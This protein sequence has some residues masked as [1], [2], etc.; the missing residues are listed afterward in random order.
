MVLR[1]RL[2]ST[3][4]A[5]VGGI[6]VFFHRLPANAEEDTILNICAQ[7]AIKVC[8]ITLVDPPDGLHPAGRSAIV[9]LDVS[10]SKHFYASCS[11][12]NVVRELTRLGDKGAPQLWYS[13]AQ[14]PV[15]AAGT[16]GEKVR[17]DDIPAVRLGHFV[18]SGSFLPL[19][20]CAESWRNT[21]LHVIP[22]AGFM[23]LHFRDP[24][25]IK[26]AFSGDMAPPDANCVDDGDDDFVSVSDYD[27]YV[28]DMHGTADMVLEAK[29]YLAHVADFVVVDLEQLALLVPVSRP[30]A[31]QIGTQGE[32]D[33]KMKWQ[34]CCVE[35]F[36][37]ASVISVTFAKYA[38]MCMALNALRSANV[39]IYFARVGN[40]VRPRDHTPASLAR[41]M[42][43]DPP[44]DT[45]TTSE[46]AHVPDAMHFA[47]ILVTSLVHKLTW[48][49][50]A[51][52]LKLTFPQLYTLLCAASEWP[53]QLP[54]VLCPELIRAI[55]RSPTHNSAVLQVLRGV[56]SDEVF[57][58][59]LFVER[60]LADA[61]TMSDITDE[62]PTCPVPQRTTVFSTGLPGKRV[63]HCPR[64]AIRTVVVTPSRLVFREPEMT[65]SNRVL[66]HFGPL[67]SHDAFLI[68]HFRDEDAVRP[69]A[70]LTLKG[71]MDMLFTHGIRIG[72]S[73]F[74]VLHWSN[75]QMRTSGLWMYAQSLHSTISCEN[76][77]E[78]VFPFGPPSPT[79][80]KYASRLALFFSSSR[81]T[82]TIPMRHAREVKDITRNGHVFTDG[83][84]RMRRAEADDV[85]R[86]IG[87]DVTPSAY[88]I[89]Y[90]GAKG[91]VVVQPKGVPL[92]DDSTFGLELPA[93]MVKF[94]SI[95]SSFEVVS[96]AAWNP[97]RLN[98]QIITLLLERGVALETMILFME[99]ALVCAGQVMVDPSCAARRLV[100]L[101]IGARSTDA[102]ALV[103]SGMRLVDDPYFATVLQFLYRIDVNRFRT[104]THIPI[105]KAAVLLG[106]CDFTGILS[107]G[108]V[109]VQI[110]ENDENKSTRRVVTGPI[111]VTKNPCLHPGD[112]LRLEAVDV[113]ALRYIVNCV[114][115][116]TTGERPLPDKI[117]GSDLD[118]DMYFC[119]WDM[120]LVTP[121]TQGQPMDYTPQDG[122]N[123]L[124][125][126]NSDESAQRA[127]H[128]YYV[129]CTTGTSLG[130][131]ANS[132]IVFAD[133]K[134]AMCDP[135]IKL[136]QLHSD[137]VDAPKTGKRIEV[138]RELRPIAYP[139]WMEKEDERAQVS[140]SETPLQ[141]LYDLCPAIARPDAVEVASDPLYDV[142]GHEAFLEKANELRTNYV[143]HLLGIMRRFGAKVEAEA[144]TGHLDRGFPGREKEMRE[145]EMT[146]AV[147]ALQKKYRGEFED[148]LRHTREDED[149]E[150]DDDTESHMCSSPIAH[151]VASAWYMATY[152]NPVVKKKLFLS[153]AWLAAPELVT[154][155]STA[156]QKRL[157]SCRVHDTIARSMARLYVT[158]GPTVTS[159]RE[160][161]EAMSYVSHALARVYGPRRVSVSLRGSSA[162]ML[163]RPADVV[164]LR[165]VF[166][167]GECSAAE[168]AAALNMEKQSDGTE[169]GVTRTGVEFTVSLGR[170]NEEEDIMARLCGWFTQCPVVIPVCFALAQWCHTHAAHTHFTTHHAWAILCDLLDATTESPPAPVSPDTWAA[171]WYI[172]WD[173]EAAVDTA[174][175]GTNNT[176]YHP[177][178][179]F[180]NFF[181]HMLKLASQDGARP[182]VHNV[183]RVEVLRVYQQLGL[184]GHV[185]T[186]IT[187]D[188]NSP[189][190]RACKCILRAVSRHVNH[191]E[192]YQQLHAAMRAST[193]SN[194]RQCA[195]DMVNVDVANDAGENGLCKLTITLRGTVEELRLGEQVLTALK[196]RLNRE[197]MTD[198]AM[199]GI[200]QLLRPEERDTLLQK[201]SDYQVVIVSGPTGCGKSTAVPLLMLLDH[202]SL[203]PKR[204]ICTQPRRVGATS[205]AERVATLSGGKVGEEVG[206][207]IGG[208]S[209]VTPGRT[210]L[211]YETNSVAMSQFLRGDVPCTHLLIDE[212]HNR[213]L[214]DDILLAVV[215]HFVLPRNPSLRVLLMSAATNVPQLVDYFATSTRATTCT[216]GAR[217]HTVTVKYLEDMPFSLRAE[218]KRYTLASLAQFVWVL[219]KD[220]TSTP[221]GA[222]ILIFLAGRA[223]I[224]NMAAELHEIEE[225]EAPR[226]AQL[227]I[228]VLHSGIPVEKQ[229]LALQPGRSA[230]GK[231]VVILA[232]DIVESSVTIPEVAIVIDT[233]HHKRKRWNADQR[234]YQL[235]VDDITQD[236]AL[237][238]AGRTGRTRTGTVYRCIA[239]AEF[240][241]LPQHCSP[242]IQSASM[243]EVLLMLHDSPLLTDPRE[244]LLQCTPTPPMKRQ[245]DEAYRK[246][247]EVGALQDRGSGKLEPTRFGRVLQRMPLD[248][249]L[250]LLVWYGF[251][252]GQLEN[253]EILAGVAQRGSPF[254]QD[255]YGTPQDALELVRV[256]Q[257]L[258]ADSD[259]LAGLRAYKAWKT[260]H[261]AQANMCAPQKMHSRRRG[262]KRRQQRMS[263]E[264]LAER[265]VDWCWQHYFSHSKLQEIEEM[266]TQIH[267][268]LAD[269]KLVDPTPRDVVVSMQSRRKAHRLARPYWDRDHPTADGQLGPVSSL[270]K[271]IGA[272]SE[273]D[274][275]VLRWT[276]CVAFCANAA[277]APS[278]DEP[279]AVYRVRRNRIKDLDAFLRTE[280]RLSKFRVAPQRDGKSAIVHFDTLAD[281]QRAVQIGT[282]ASGPNFP[283]S[284]AP[285]PRMSSDTRGSLQWSAADIAFP[286]DGVCMPVITAGRMAIGAQ[287]LLI[288]DNRFLFSAVTLVP[289]VILPLALATRAHN[290]I[291]HSRTFTTTI[292]DREEKCEIHQ[293]LYALCRDLLRAV[294]WRNSDPNTT[295]QRECAR[296]AGTLMHAAEALNVALVAEQPNAGRS[297]TIEL[298]QIPSSE[299]GRVL[300]KGGANVRLC[301][302]SYKNVRID[303]PKLG[304]GGHVTVM[305]PPEEAQKCAD[306][307]LRSV[308]RGGTSRAALPHLFG[309]EDDEDVLAHLLQGL[310]R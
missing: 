268:I 299:F 77:R 175:A 308:G 74:R 211:L 33:E 15:D 54:G 104:K 57:P 310:F 264:M 263:P 131:I 282:M 186:V 147:R 53:V 249:E 221:V 218:S 199:A 305:G 301:R 68:V 160:R 192:I 7:L 139:S 106:V 84:G 121:V 258:C 49:T 43:G 154:L 237:Q 248:P 226:Y 150:G 105:E 174:L 138:P 52:A 256:K 266:A 41:H 242:Q 216:V 230:H 28:D 80:C 30:P 146:A 42:R 37:G 65:L 184:D 159:H 135:C 113:P 94:K 195:P 208:M 86:A 115:F 63:H 16:A 270:N 288:G 88:Q 58:D 48:G 99:R 13:L 173:A 64:Y 134:G 269:F 83:C 286:S 36:G 45:M 251:H 243:A 23:L 50:M 141:T 144:V 247:I 215:K 261:T 171:T 44:R 204:V 236:E 55:Q 126:G 223:D 69:M 125:I 19:R 119:T 162:L 228:K 246:L 235:C 101:A 205:L 109:F 197:S 114:V 90:G 201:V 296:C 224:S 31:F 172:T 35:G 227:D 117:S 103:R 209:E 165:C 239:K 156:T 107:E 85:A 240:N 253:V 157:H 142:A 133:E 202:N 283:Y 280:L 116:P 213:T 257:A 259:L 70:G 220:R 34:R 295:S 32:H 250:A 189:N 18:R 112:I 302:D 51:D 271:C 1:D 207:R 255:P 177:G 9:Q 137:A 193:T 194:A 89:R 56:M 39:F 277:P 93:S 75:S 182:L 25:C 4:L 293:Q 298:T 92:S 279:I 225:T 190:T 179:M 158:R 198:T 274:H 149:D 267:D 5:N 303:V 124:S 110:D 122:S 118:G 306:H 11:E 217:Q 252:C 6:C 151:R 120:D 145:A 38:H 143:D 188:A 233:M 98:R 153:F 148:Q 27:D 61:H 22:K 164:E 73:H 128:E 229:Q 289:L 166:S 281:M 10:T 67:V 29:I 167:H 91:V 275:R 181:V 21:R 183:L 245:V 108:Q 129:Q 100:D 176:T 163:W 81:P 273:D 294:D 290:G 262:K 136:A 62:P 231:R 300:G 71:R 222:A 307:I 285:R 12:E 254:L 130:V 24:A 232:T 155:F 14:L 297:K 96:W 178:A 191:S 287:S 72:C 59:A 20:D 304:E 66:A 26:L 206:Y 60:V 278:S 8:V 212:V 210:R 87:L 78:W 170:D 95:H 161:V 260:F 309:G 17:I 123:E 185:D 152:T 265:E 140:S 40:V 234:E 46:R 111:I 79:P 214:F 180:Y 238:R 276:I 47:S 3:K 82:I 284:H 292:R 244:F 200:G 241:N 76:I 102:R 272:F 203:G 169:R 168:V 97:A 291:S 196:H 187:K 127:L 2:P 132:H 219:H